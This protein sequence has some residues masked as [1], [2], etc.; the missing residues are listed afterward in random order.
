[1]VILL[2]LK[3]Q[4]KVAKLHGSGDTRW[5]RLVTQLAVS[6]QASVDQTRDVLGLQ[7]GCA[8]RKGGRQ[9]DVGQRVLKLD[10]STGIHNITS[11]LRSPQCRQFV[12]GELAVSAQAAENG[13]KVVFLLQGQGGICESRKGL[14][15]TGD[16]RRNGESHGRHIRDKPV[17]AG[18]LLSCSQDWHALWRESDIDEMLLAGKRP[19]GP[20]GVKHTVNAG[21]LLAGVLVDDDCSNLVLKGAIIL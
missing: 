16:K 1:M 19:A 12:A 21:Q 3:R 17:D 5:Q 18:L 15:R 10:H 4:A 13:A 8:L 7:G 9:L 2:V 11:G 6:G 20:L 14:V